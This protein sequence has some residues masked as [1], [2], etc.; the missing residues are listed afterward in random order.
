M[1]HP[2]LPLTEAYSL[3]VSGLKEAQ[4]RGISQ[5]LNRFVQ[6]CGRSGPVTDL[7][8]QTVATYAEWVSMSGGDVAR[9]LDPVKAFLTFLK[10]KEIIGISLAPHMRIPK[11]KGKGRNSLDN[12]AVAL[13]QL[14]KEG[15]QQLTARLDSLK[16][17]RIKV[18]SDIGRAMADKDF[19]ENAPLEAAKERQGLVESMIRDLEHTLNRA[20]ITDDVA[21]AAAVR[22]AIGAKVVLKDSGSGREV[23]YVVVHPREA[24]PTERKISSE[25]PVGKALMN[26]GEGD[27]VKVSAPK[28][29]IQYRIQKIQRR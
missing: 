19:R 11:G 9:K 14:T 7:T 24:N 27:E 12:E 10:R 6:W 8:P 1:Q 25:S 3:Y 28:G 18:I 4:K 15:H 16:Q 17:E 13:A 20:I 22:V 21:L 26:K 2:G 23:S 29:T 5:D